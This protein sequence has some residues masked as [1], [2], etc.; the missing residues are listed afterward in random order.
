MAERE[1]R[2]ETALIGRNGVDTLG[3]TFADF[4]VPGI[5]RGLR[6]EGDEVVDGLGGWVRLREECRG[7][8]SGTEGKEG[9]GMY[10]C[11]YVAW[12]RKSLE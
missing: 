4:A 8:L 5:T 6:G 11:L 7:C 2:P 10:W 12:A 3:D 9:E 1:G